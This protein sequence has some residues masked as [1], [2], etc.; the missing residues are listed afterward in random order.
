[1]V[2]YYLFQEMAT[3]SLFQRVEMIFLQPY[4]PTFISIGYYDHL[5]ILLLQPLLLAYQIPH[6]EA[7]SPKL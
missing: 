7:P 6:L 5:V 3:M 2:L 1:M 4:N